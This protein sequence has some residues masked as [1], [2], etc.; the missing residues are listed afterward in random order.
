MSA[1]GV[2]ISA[3]GEVSSR[4]VLQ[5]P[6]HW[7][8]LDFISDLH[9]Q[10][11]AVS[12]FNAWQ[13]YLQTTR[14]DAV[15]IL[16][17][18]FDVWVGDDLLNGNVGAD[19]ASAFAAAC[20]QTLS[21]A[22]QRLSVFLMH[23]NRDFLLGT[24]FAQA[25]KLTLLNDPTVL[26]FADVRCLL[27]HGDALCLADTDYMR[28]RM[29]VR[30]PAWQQDFLHLPLVQRQERAL[31]LRA[32]SE[33]R[34]RSG[35]ACIDVDNAAAQDWLRAAQAQSLIHGHTHRPGQHAMA[36]GM[37]RLVLS[38]WDLDAT[39]ARAQVLRLNATL[40]NRV[41]GDLVQRLTLAQAAAQRQT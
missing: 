19:S 40:E 23:G 29:Q 41:G 3:Y 39:P 11:D 22:A 18:L 25:C 12:T 30:S 17:D 28:F 8:R 14:A 24:A 27:S 9:L 7:Q 6:K 33:A 1:S 34:K 10:L 2:G 20:V 32:Q 38:D 16:G 13:D 21:A 15:F 26:V 4:P 31:A 36:N 35:A 5:A 37:R